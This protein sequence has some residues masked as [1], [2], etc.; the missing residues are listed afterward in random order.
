MQTRI[1]LLLNYLN[2]QQFQPVLK[3]GRE[4]AD[5]YRNRT[6]SIEKLNLKKKEKNVEKLF[7]TTYRIDT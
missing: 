6:S 3:C 1:L 2:S 7:S 5:F 4:Y